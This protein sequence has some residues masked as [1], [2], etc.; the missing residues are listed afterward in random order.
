MVICL[1]NEIINVFLI[2]FDQFDMLPLT[3]IDDR[4]Q[5]FFKGILLLNLILCEMMSS[6]FIDRYIFYHPS[7]F[8]L[9]DGLRIHTNEGWKLKNKGEDQEQN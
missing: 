2:G 6:L 8:D 4:S 1:F 7:L 9:L 3:E 5:V